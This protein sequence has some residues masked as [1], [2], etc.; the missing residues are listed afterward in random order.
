MTS[1]SSADQREQLESVTSHQRAH[2]G[3]AGSTGRD[4]VA[5]ARELD[6]LRDLWRR[7][8]EGELRERPGRACAPQHSAVTTG[9]AA[10]T[11]SRNTAMFATI[12]PIVYIAKVCPMV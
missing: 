4:S 7:Y 5:Q 10:S 1:N 8:E 3:S 11:H 9:Q 2:T 12:L 6:D